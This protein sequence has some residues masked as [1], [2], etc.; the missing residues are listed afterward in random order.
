VS[1]A[2]VRRSGARGF[3]AKADLPGA[4]LDILLAPP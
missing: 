1:P 3:L 2:D 4:R